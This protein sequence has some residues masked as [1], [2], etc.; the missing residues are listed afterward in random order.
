MRDA[1][2][3]HQHR[4]GAVGARYLGLPPVVGVHRVPRALEAARRIGLLRLVRQ[5]HDHFA[6]DVDAFE[7]VVVV[8]GRRD[9]IAGKDERRRDGHVD[10]ALA[11][12]REVGSLRVIAVLRAA[13]LRRDPRGEPGVL[14]VD[15]RVDHRKVLEE[16]VAVADRL[17]PRAVEEAGDVVGRD[18]SLAAHRVAARHRIRGE[19]EDVPLQR[20]GADRLEAG[21]CV[22]VE[23]DGE[24]RDEDEAEELFTHARNIHSPSSGPFTRTVEEPQGTKTTKPRNHETTKGRCHEGSKARRMR[25][26]RAVRRA[27]RSADAGQEAAVNESG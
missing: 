9:A 13:G 6:G 23:R 25:N 26:W 8:L 19:E 15:V 17:Q 24:E 18:A 4:A 3:H 27:A 7:V 22:S 20:V 5:H 2:L 16:G 21:D 12:Q 11:R 1:L 10:V 14:T